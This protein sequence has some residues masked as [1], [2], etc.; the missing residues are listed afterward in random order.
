MLLDL[1]F[2][3]LLALIAA[4]VILV[5]YYA[6]H[7]PTPTPPT[8][9]HPGASWEDHEIMAHH[10]LS[11]LDWLDLTDARRARFRNDFYSSTGL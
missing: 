8:R 5:A 11:L 7:H 6:T 4:A 1:N 2:Y 3:A 10:G 9:K